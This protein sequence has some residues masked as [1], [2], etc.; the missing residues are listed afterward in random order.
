MYAMTRT[1]EDAA[2]ILNGYESGYVTNDGNICYST[3]PDV[4]VGH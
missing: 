2:G 4:K 1:L 3:N